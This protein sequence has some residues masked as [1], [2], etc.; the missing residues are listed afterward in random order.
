MTNNKNNYSKQNEIS[1][2]IGVR[3]QF[4]KSVVLIRRRIVKCQSI[5][6]VH[7]KE[8]KHFYAKIYRA[9]EVSKIR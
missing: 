5:F 3:S 6:V 1:Y 7:L 9:C 8:F 2:V 4:F